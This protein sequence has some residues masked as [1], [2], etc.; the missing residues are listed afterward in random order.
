[1]GPFELSSGERILRRDGLVLPLGGR[2]L[3]ILIYLVERS[4]EV[5]TKKELID[6]AWPDVV[7]EEGSL[8]VQIAAIRKALG[9]GK[10]GNRYIAN[11]RGRGY[12]F[13][14]TVAPFGGGTEN[15]NAK[16]RRQRRLPLRPIMMIGRKAVLSEVS[17]RLREERFGP[18]GIGKTTVA[19]AVSRAA[20]EEFKGPVHFLDLEGLTD[21]HHVVEAVATSLRF[22]ANSKAPRLELVDR[23]GSLKLLII[24]DSCEDAIEAIPLV[25]EQ[26]YKETD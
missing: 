20:A 21:S 16:F 6:H 18:G 14:G 5:V 17:H 8:R 1:L 12:S 19:L 15:R 4:G 11:I 25:G 7:V 26:L 10:F 9:D 24:L 23:V 13:V 22:A 2:A 3:E